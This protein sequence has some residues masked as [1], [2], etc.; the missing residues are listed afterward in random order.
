MIHV[1]CGNNKQTQNDTHIRSRLRLALVSPAY[2]HVSI[3]LASCTPSYIRSRGLGRP[4]HLP[5]TV[6]HAH[7]NSRI[8]TQLS[9]HH[10]ST[11]ADCNPVGHRMWC[12]AWCMVLTVALAVTAIIVRVGRL[13]LRL[14]LRLHLHLRLCIMLLLCCTAI[15]EAIWV[16]IAHWYP[17]AI[18]IQRLVWV[19]L[20][21]LLEAEGSAGGGGYV[22][23]IPR[24][25]TI[26]TIVL[27]ETGVS[28]P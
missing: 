9:R 26:S 6:L 11:P 8:H 16:W 14:R 7:S 18:S 21:M 4:A 19:L 15:S 10:W 20:L 12:M 23:H 1:L 2:L 13:H 5:T 28:L 24:I 3:L 17:I 25:T 27:R 22:A